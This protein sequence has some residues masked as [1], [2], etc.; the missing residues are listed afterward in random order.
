[1]KLRGYVIQ[2]TDKA[3]LFQI[4]SDECGFHLGGLTEWFPKS[5]IRLPKVLHDKEIRIY[6]QNWLYDS[7]IPYD[8]F[9]R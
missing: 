9:A 1:M 5:H 8:E 2:E 7:K 6:V 3:I 4:T